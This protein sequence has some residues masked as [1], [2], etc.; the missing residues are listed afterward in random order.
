MTLQNETIASAFK[1]HF[2][3]YWHSR[4]NFHQIL[5]IFS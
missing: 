1:T 3:D 5:K 4:Y 2:M